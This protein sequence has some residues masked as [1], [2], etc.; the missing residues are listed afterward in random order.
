MGLCFS[1]SRSRDKF[2]AKSTKICQIHSAVSPVYL[3]H[4]T[5][6]SSHVNRLSA[7]YVEDRMATSFSNMNLTNP[8]KGLVSK[9]R[10]RYKKDGF[11]LDLTYITDNIIA[12]GYPAS[13]IEGVYR[14][15]IDDVVKFLDKKHLDHYYIYNLCSERS[16][17]KSKFHNRVKV[18]PFD[19]HNPPK[20]DSIQP[21]CNDVKEWLSKDERNVA[22]VHCKA[23]KGRT[24]TMICCY[25][26]HSGMF[27]SADEAL[28]HYGKTRTQ[29]KKG[30]TIPSQVRYVRYYEKLVRG[31]L[32]YTPVSMYIKEFIF[33]PV[34]NF[35]GGQG[36]LSFTI[37]H[38]TLQQEGEKLTQKCKK[39]R[40]NDAFEVKKADSPFSIKLDYCLPLTGDIKVEFYNKS[41]MRKEK[42]FQFWFNTFFITDVVDVNGYVDRNG[43][44]EDCCYVLSFD[45]NELDIVNKKDK[46]N[47]VFSADFKLTMLLQRI[48]RDDCCPSTYERPSQVQD[49]PSESSADSSDDYTNEEDDW[50]SVLDGEHLDP[51][52]VG[53]RILSECELASQLTS[54]SSEQQ[55]ELLIV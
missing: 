22:A 16:Y 49:T 25:L 45:K 42:L 15:H 33:N 46:Q 38:Q 24:G 54:S 51:R 44:G 23:G 35:V 10:Y 31:N 52:G 5:P 9:R 17:D 8:I 4:E 3:P 53:Y 6:C 48:P 26:L 55:P 7:P 50:D 39:L 43:S 47:K 21:F 11:N 14:N 40:K 18:F 27:P 19:D 13:N 2:K 20:I 36:C 28:C 37:S 41:M 1:C 30:V 12:M 32:N 34:P 29:D